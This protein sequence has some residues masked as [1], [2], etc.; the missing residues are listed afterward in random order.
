MTIL[1]IEDEKPIAQVLADHLVHE[2]HEVRVAHDGRNGLEQARSEDIDLILLDLMLPLMN[3]YEVCSALRDEG[4]STPIITLTA[5][6]EKIDKVTDLDLG[7]DDYTNKPVGL[8]GLLVSIRAVSRRIGDR[9]DMG[10]VTVGPAEVDF[11]RFLVTRSGE[12]V[13]EDAASQPGDLSAP[14]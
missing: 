13:R 8:R 9:P 7:A 12:S 3:E 11:D 5:K 4:I 6:G 10:T 1:I 14:R 2:G